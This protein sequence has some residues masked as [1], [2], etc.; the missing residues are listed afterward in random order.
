MHI[1]RFYY[2]I[3]ANSNAIRVSYST[4]STKSNFAKYQHILLYIPLYLF[5]IQLDDN[6]NNK[7][8]SS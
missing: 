2:S 6:L 3:H 5:F 7:S 8:S 1:P 4:K